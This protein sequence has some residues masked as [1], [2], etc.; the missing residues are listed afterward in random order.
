ML[1]FSPTVRLARGR[2]RGEST[3]FECHLCS[4]PRR[5]R[6]SGSNRFFSSSSREVERLASIDKACG[7]GSLI[8]AGLIPQ[9]YSEPSKYFQHATVNAGY[10][11]SFRRISRRGTVSKPRDISLFRRRSRWM[12]RERRNAMYLTLVRL[13]LFRS[14]GICL[15]M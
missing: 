3:R 5:G 13:F 14:A 8:E 1:I 6:G 11:R 7:T 10:N 12:G 15:F 9:L 4:D 2:A